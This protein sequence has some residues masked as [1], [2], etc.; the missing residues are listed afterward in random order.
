MPWP[1][2]ETA[3]KVQV[4]AAEWD[5]P[6]VGLQRF[7]RV[8]IRM[9]GRGGAT[10]ELGRRILSAPAPPGVCGQVRAHRI[11]A[12]RQGRLLRPDNVTSANRALQVLVILGRAHPA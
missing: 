8:G 2:N 7:Y 4:I 5:I 3:E 11:D 1:L 6:N 9:V 12:R 10:G